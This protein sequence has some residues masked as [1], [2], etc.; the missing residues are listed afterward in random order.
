MLPQ[1][2][3]PLCACRYHVKEMLGQGTFGQVVKCYWDDTKEA[4]ALKVIKNQTAFFHQVLAAC[5]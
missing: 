3:Q 5:F 4:V 2:T 1:L